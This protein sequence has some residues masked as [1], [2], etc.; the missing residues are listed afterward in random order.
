MVPYRAADLERLGAGILHAVGAPQDVAEQV[1]RSLVLS[2]LLGHDSHGVMRIPRY[3]EAVEKGTVL[4]AARP[5][6][7][8]ET[9]TTATVDGQWAFGQITAHHAIQV[10]IVK[11][12]SGQTAAVS[13][14][15]CNHIG[16]LGEY[17]EL[18]ARQGLVAFM[19]GASF[20]RG[21]TAPHGGAARVLGTNPLSFAVPAGET[22]P[23]VVDFATSATAEG[24]LSVARSKGSR[25]RR[26][27]SSTRTA[28]RAPTPTTITAA[29][30]CSPSEDTRATDCR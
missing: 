30:P 8:T 6:L 3:V 29:A 27:S 24:K 18:A 25:W 14:V 13:V 10:A 26:A 21:A 1:A 19:V 2:N 20:G 9:T 28:T 12:R 16:R 7:V 11:A 15:R 23:V 17:T 5:T 4:P 22:G